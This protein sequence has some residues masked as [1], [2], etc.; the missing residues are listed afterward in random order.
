M[1]TNLVTYGADYYSKT[2]RP[3]RK[4]NLL[5]YSDERSRLE[6]Q[7]E[8]FLIE[9]ENKARQQTKLL[10]SFADQ[11]D[12]MLQKSLNGVSLIEINNA[13]FGKGNGLEKGLLSLVQQI[14]REM[15]KGTLQKTSL[16]DLLNS[17]INKMNTN[18]GKTFFTIEENTQQRIKSFQYKLLF[19]KNPKQALNDL[20]A[21]INNSNITSSKESEV[22]EL[23]SGIMAYVAEQIANGGQRAIL[24]GV[25]QVVQAVGKQTYS[26][27]GQIGSV[28]RQQK[29]DVVYNDTFTI[30]VKDYVTKPKIIDGSLVLSSSNWGITLQSTAQPQ[31]FFTSWIVENLDTS[32][33]TIA[34]RYGTDVATYLINNL[35]FYY[36]RYIDRDINIQIGNDLGRVFRIYAPVFLMFTAFHGSYYRG[37]KKILHQTQTQSIPGAL[38]FTKSYFISMGDLI[39]SIV[40][41]SNASL[42]IGFPRTSAAIKSIDEQVES[43]PRAGHY[44]RDIATNSNSPSETIAARGEIFNSKLGLQ[45]RLKLDAIK[46]ALA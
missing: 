30:S 1:A 13:L 27:G 35:Y 39:R 19:G 40:N 32:L 17:Y 24:K 14:I 23:T 11:C 41:Q 18:I 28:G 3:R 20:L 43:G 25:D 31:N 33:K 45:V 42:Y 15:Q 22:A 6:G 9:M 16:E 21:L 44:K 5:F 4:T 12:A 8:K 37:L 38:Y 26:T 34:K 2:Q 29:T 46:V 7:Y 36:Y 10:L